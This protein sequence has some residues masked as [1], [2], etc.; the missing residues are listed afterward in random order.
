MDR[1]LRAMLIR[2]W[3]TSAI[4]PLFLLVFAGSYVVSNHV[5][6]LTLWL[7]FAPPILVGCVGTTATAWRVHQRLVREHQPQPRPGTR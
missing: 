5:S 3:V 1:E 2:L 4:M 6:A 7:G